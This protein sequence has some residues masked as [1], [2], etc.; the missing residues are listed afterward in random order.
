MTLR[1]L[2]TVA[3]LLLAV[4]ARA[5]LTFLD[6][7][8]ITPGNDADRI[9]LTQTSVTSGAS[10]IDFTGG[11]LRVAVFK[12]DI[13]LCTGCNVTLSIE[14]VDPDS[15]S[16]F[17]WYAPTA[18][19]T[20]GVTRYY[21]GGSGAVTTGSVLTGAVSRFM[22]AK[23]RVSVLITGTASYVLSGMTW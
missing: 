5:Q 18:L 11:S 1:L 22:P 4:Q 8:A 19:T 14:A 6:D 10:S 12:L 21:V 3:L 13:T 15:T 7:P 20:T 2:L 9:I 23:F 16:Y 17:S